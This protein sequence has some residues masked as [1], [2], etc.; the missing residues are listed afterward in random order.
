MR[1]EEEVEVLGMMKSESSQG[2]PPPHRVSFKPR[3][4][5]SHMHFRERVS[6]DLLNIVSLEFETM[7]QI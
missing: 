3:E 5:G 1:P 4:V 6:L 7:E 2:M